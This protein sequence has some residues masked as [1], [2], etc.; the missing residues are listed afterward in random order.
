MEGGLGDLKKIENTTVRGATASGK[1][2]IK[3][4]LFGGLS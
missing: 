1:K 2:R 4:K 3:K